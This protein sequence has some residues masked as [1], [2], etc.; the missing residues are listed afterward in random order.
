MDDA[1]L[2]ARL[3]A[4]AVPPPV[5]QVRQVRPLPDWPVVHRELRRKG[6][7][8]ALHWMEY[9]TAHPDGYQHSWFCAAYRRWQDYLDVV[10]RQ[11]HRAGEKLFVD[12]AG[13]T[14]PIVDADTG[15]VWQAEL[16]VPVLGAS[17][18]TYA[19]A[20]PSQEPPHWI[21]A[22]VHAFSFLEGCTDAGKG[23]HLVALEL[24]GHHDDAV[25]GR[26]H[27]RQPSCPP[28]LT[29]GW[30]GGPPGARRRGRAAA[31]SRDRPAGRASCSA[32][33]EAGTR[34][35]AAGRTLRRS[36]VARRRV[37]R[38]L[39][40]AE[41]GV[42]PAILERVRSSEAPYRCRCPHAGAV[43]ISRRKSENPWN[44]RTECRGTG[45]RMR[46]GSA[47]KVLQETIAG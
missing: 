46:V 30:T 4:R 42:A 37:S 12:F 15:E 36:P 29:A 16:F 11:E 27:V 26:R 43:T 41:R 7:T 9:K 8:L 23:G 25:R 39:R 21:N 35:A 3:F 13:Q 32:T 38:I 45:V 2:E 34:V 28:R 10:M 14:I 22:H 6:V 18:H 24:L 31:A 44:G 17:S 47:A 20:P 40:M 5:R 19:E 1:Q 33:V